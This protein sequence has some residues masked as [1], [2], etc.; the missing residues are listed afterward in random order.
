LE[1]HDEGDAYDAQGVCRF[2]EEDA[3]GDAEDEANQDA[4]AQARAKAPAPNLVSADFRCRVSSMERV[5][6][7]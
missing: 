1:Q 2:A 3:G 7:S 5:G 4:L 6:L